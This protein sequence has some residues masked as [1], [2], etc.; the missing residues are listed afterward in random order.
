MRY[1]IKFTKEG[2]IKFI[3]H[4]DLMRTIQKVI[5]RSELPIEYSKG[6]NPHMA[7]SIA[8][9]LS[10]GVYSEG[11]YMD[12]VLVEEMN[13]EKIISQLNEYSARGIRFLT[14]TKIP[15]PEPNQ[16]KIPQG[17][18][19]VD[20]ARYTIRMQYNDVSKVISEIDSLMNEAE[21]TMLKKSKKGEKE[22]NIKPLVHEIK[23]W[24]KDDE[25]VINTLISS[26]SRDHLSPDL[27]A[28]L[29]GKKT[30]GFCEDSFINIKR[31][32]M[33]FIS[34]KKVLPL[35]KIV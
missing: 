11:E 22:V 17:M 19:L 14:A 20:A 27:L 10:V 9:P 32:E 15:A 21:W 25:L 16:K 30:T 31:E 4:L 13:E 2:D 35:Y 3:S 5:R 12:I 8:Q 34:G 29:I 26:G 7:L 1:L 23:Y 18:A 33:Y 24:V 28:S 6:F